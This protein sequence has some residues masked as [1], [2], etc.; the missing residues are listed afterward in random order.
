MIVPAVIDRQ[1]NLLS[2]YLHILQQRVEETVFNYCME[3]KFAYT[4]RTK[5][6]QSLAEKIESGRY[7]GWSELDDLFACTVIVPTLAEEGSVLEFLQ[8]VFSEVRIIRRGQLEKAPDVFRFDAPRFI[9]RL[10]P[11]EGT[12]LPS[13]INQISFE[14][15]IRSAFEHAWSVTTHALAYKTRRVDWTHLRLAAQLKAAVEQL[16]S[17]VL[18]YENLAQGIVRAPWPEVVVKSKIT[19]RFSMLVAEKKI[20]SELA[21]KDW[22]RFSENLYSLLQSC[23]DYPSSRQDRPHFIDESLEILAE[24]IEQLGPKSFPRSISLHQL[25]LGILAQKGRVRFPLRRFTPIITPELQ[26][27]YPAVRA[28]TNRFTF[29]GETI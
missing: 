9:G 22:S 25:T 10:R 16:D 2:P 8:Q 28:L 6:V 7:S 15:Q 17:L 14:V 3:R 26:M 5:E 13:E 19:G 23:P 21:P 29:G 4:G 20:P 1:F 12:D 18:A 24:E 27:L 11:I